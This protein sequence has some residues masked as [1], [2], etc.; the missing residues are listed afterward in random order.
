MRQLNSCSAFSRS[1]CIPIVGKVNYVNFGFFRVS[2]ETRDAAPVGTGPGNKKMKSNFGG[3]GGSEGQETGDYIHRSWL[4]FYFSSMSIQ[5][6]GDVIVQRMKVATLDCRSRPHP[7]IH[8]D[9]N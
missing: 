8:S 5:L 7:H 2:L 3:V 1:G 9:L 6:K 4:H